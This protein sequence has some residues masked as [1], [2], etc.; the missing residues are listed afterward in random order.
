M[1]STPR[2]TRDLR[3]GWL[4]RARGLSANL[5]LLGGS[6][7]FSLLLGELGVRL[8]SPIGPALLV[9]DP[10]V[11]KRFVAG[12]TERVFV[13]ECG[14]AV[15]IRFNRDGLRGRD[16]PLRP[17]PGRHRIALIGD[18]MIASLA[19]EE[20]RTIARQLERRLER[21]GT[22]SRFEVLNG[23]ISSSSTG[24]ELALY[25]EVLS[26][27]S[28]ELVILAFYEGNDLADNSAELTR[29]TRL[30][31][32]LD[33]AGRLRQLP[34]ARAPQPLSRWLDRH[35]RLYVWQKDAVR[36]AR[37]ALRS[38]VGEVDAT[39]LV[40][41]EP[42]PEAVAR[43]WAVTDAL[44]RAFRDEVEA[45]GARLVLVSIPAAVSIYDDLWT[46]LA[47][48]ARAKG[49]R[50]RPDHAT[51]RLE[52]LGREASVP[53][54]SLRPSFLSATPHRDSRLAAE[55][56]FIEGRY[57]W[58]DRGN[59]LA[60]EAV[61]RFLGAGGLLRNSPTPACPAAGV[62]EWANLSLSSR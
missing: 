52:R 28:P 18:S 10:V 53:F 5:G 38:R 2:T 36:R 37:A 49:I 15:D 9:A 60:A 55:Q 24:S 23:G 51:L 16:R 31:F 43:A 58:N 4:R 33:E 50:L 17:P 22:A 47:E 48:R 3:P 54:L 7:V 8:F 27:Y 32:D 34:F 40:F 20:E 19:T 56:L 59:A 14:C 41:A 21:C 61:F 44:V 46:E 26:R 35:S 57:H 6:L 30:Y 45:R 42:E 25:R 12:F 29:A 1:P 11:G 39:D 13:P 62:G